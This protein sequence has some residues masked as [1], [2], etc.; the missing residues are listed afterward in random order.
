[1][2]KRLTD[3]TLISQLPIKRKFLSPCRVADLQL[4]S[5]AVYGGVSTRDLLNDHCRKRRRSVE[6]P[7]VPQEEAPLDLTAT[8][9]DA[10]KE[11]ISMS[12]AQTCGRYN[13]SLNSTTARKRRR[14]EY[15]ESGTIASEVCTKTD[16]DSE[17]CTY[18]SFQYWR[19]PLP[20]LDLSLLEETTE[21]CQ[22][23]HNSN[24]RNAL[25]AME[26]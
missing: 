7:D 21:H 15:V 6:I 8:T 23:K 2:A 3:D 4:G 20:Q 22:V 1:M 13:E 18:N 5:M 19:V 25:D 11:S 24:V 12:H 17:D 14:E 16:I 9:P 10:R 26:T